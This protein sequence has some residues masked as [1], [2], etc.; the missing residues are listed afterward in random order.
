MKRAKSLLCLILITCFLLSQA[1]LAQSVRGSIAGQIVDASKKPVPAAQITVVE[2]ETNRSRTVTADR[3]GVFSITFIPPGWYRI[4]VNGA[5]FQRNTSQ[6]V[7]LRVNQEIWIEIPMLPEKSTEHVD[8]TASRDLLKTESATLS[9]VIPNRDIQGLPLDGRNFYELSLL[10]PGAVPAAQGSAGSVRGDFALNVNGAREDSNN[11]LLD[12]VFNGDPKLNGFA[13]NPPVDAIREYEVLT[14]ASDASFGRNVGAQVNVVMRS[15]TNHLHG[16][17]YEFLRNSVLDSQNYFAPSYEPSPKNI[18]NQFGASLG[19]AIVKDRTFY[20]LDYEGRRVREGITNTTNVPTALE[21]IG[22]FSKSRLIPID[23]FTQQ[24]FPG[25]VIPKSRLDPIGLAISALYPLPNLSTPGQN[26]VS[27]PSLRDRDDHFDLRVDHILSKSSDLTFRYSFGDR[28]LFEPFA[29]PA[30]AAVPG[31]GNT[32]PRRGQNAMIGETHIFSPNLLNEVRLGFDRVSIAVN[33]ENQNNNLNKAVGL[34]VVSSNPRDN[35]L[36]LINVAGFSTLGDEINNPQRGVTNHYELVDHASYARGRS[37]FKFGADIRVLQQNAFRDVESRGFIYFVG[38]T[39]NALA[40]MLQ[41]FPSVSGA[42]HLDN[43]QHLRTQSY[44]FFAQDTWRIRPNLT[45]SLGV[46]YEFNKPP[47]DAQDRANIYDPA[48][49]SIVPVGRNGIPRA[50]FNSDRNN[51]APRLG[52][53]WTPGSTPKM[54]VRSGYGLYYDQSALA[55]SEGLYFSPPYFNSQLYIP[56]QQFP[57][58]LANPFPANYPFPIP[59]SAFSFER[60]LRTPYMQQWNFSLERQIGNFAVAELAYVGTKGTKLIDGRDINQ[61][62]ASPRQPN[63]RPVPQFADINALESRGNSTY[64]SFQARFQQRLHAGLSALASYTFSKSID[65]A[66]GF[67]ASAGDPNYPQD[68]NNAR[69]ERARSDFD[70]RHRFTLSYSYDLPLPRNNILLRGWQTNGIWSFQTGRPFTVGLLPGVDN[71][72]TGV[73]TL[74]FGSKDRPN[75]TGDPSLS[76]P[77]PARWFNTAAFAQSPYGTFGSA[78]RDILT[79]PGFSSINVSVIKNTTLR[80]RATLQFR[81]EL[82]NLLDRANFDLP[83]NF[84]GSPTFGRILSAGSPRR[85]QFG[86]KLLF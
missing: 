15:G 16:A 46:R 60:N 43:P 55:Q 36:S 80:E 77:S 30:Y 51:F 6:R 58:F 52:F 54:V 78:G 12:G 50:G 35:G 81:A 22:D 65:D 18:R 17:V 84:L 75:V 62:A 5:G 21:R 61:A 57:I 53:A 63:L 37:L 45:L 7:N 74:G 47:V 39:G 9:T 19:G 27:S 44:D 25:F 59:G 10:V 8:V 49:H 67:F 23:L 76:N 70:V 38:F 26:F 68:S 28:D 13:V 4:D 1:I 86:L 33:Q 14:N 71:S 34:P 32:V 2:E 73:P 31:Y 64:N 85:V 24:P 56:L 40:E 69:A 72:N 42:A 41:G 48:T 79:G 11:F 82:F 29:G 83:G 20:F 3:Q 66:S